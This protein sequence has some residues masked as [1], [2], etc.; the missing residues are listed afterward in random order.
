MGKIIP[1]EKMQYEDAQ[2]AVDEVQVTYEQR[3]DC[4]ENEDE[5]QSITLTARNNGVGRFVNIKTDNWSID[6]PEELVMITKDFMQR[7][8]IEEDKIDIPENLTEKE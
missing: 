8:G 1:F 7:A 4:T 3:G 5:V 6:G 2:I